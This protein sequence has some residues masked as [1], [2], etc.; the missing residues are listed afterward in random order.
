MD[1]EP[2]L[3]KGFSGKVSEYGDRLYRYINRDSYSNKI[4]IE[5]FKNLT[6]RVLWGEA[7]FYQNSGESGL[8]SRDYREIDF[9]ALKGFKWVWR[10]RSF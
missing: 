4:T 5:N 7:K 8:E 2:N 3:A 9:M 6:L 1:L 10:E